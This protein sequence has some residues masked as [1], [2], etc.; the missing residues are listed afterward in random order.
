MNFGKVNSNRIYSLEK[1][2]DKIQLVMNVKEQDQTESMFFDKVKLNI[3]HFF[4]E[5]LIVL[6]VDDEI[7]LILNSFMQIYE[8]T[9]FIESAP[10]CHKR[11]RDTYAISDGRIRLVQR[12]L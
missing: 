5:K 11:L 7:N 2:N 3:L 1:K 9:G 10:K 12:V 8:E 4:I 6:L